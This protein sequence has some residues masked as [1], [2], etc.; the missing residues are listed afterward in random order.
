MRLQENHG[1]QNSPVGGG[2]PYLAS[3][4]IIEIS[5][6]YF[7]EK[8]LTVKGNMACKAKKCYLRHTMQ[9]LQ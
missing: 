1:L 8:I 6:I 9:R 4:L 7:K 5:S 2:K 3:G